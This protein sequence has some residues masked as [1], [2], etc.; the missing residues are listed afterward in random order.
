MAR[1]DLDALVD[2]LNKAPAGRMAHPRT[3]HF[4]PL[5]IALGAA[6]DGAVSRA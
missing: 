5:F 2:F 1:R 6:G 4:A 3:E